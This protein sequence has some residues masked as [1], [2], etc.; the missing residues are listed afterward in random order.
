MSEIM[1]QLSRDI[2]D[3]ADR[4]GEDALR[5]ALWHLLR[6]A[7]DDR[8]AKVGAISEVVVFGEEPRSA[9][10]KHRDPSE[11]EL[12]LDVTVFDGKY[13]IISG[14]KQP[15]NALRNGS[16]WRDLVGDKMVY[17]LASTL[18]GLCEEVVELLATPD[19]KNKHRMLALCEK[20][21]IILGSQ[22][23]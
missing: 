16:P 1:R 7:M 3:K 5:Q 9:E 21:R 15:L 11:R 18:Q 10:K 2:F 19:L 4:E 6:E 8:Y 22:S 20:A 23:R 14:P 17:A 12:T 13:R